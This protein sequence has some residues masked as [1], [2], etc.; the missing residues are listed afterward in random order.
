MINSLKT[1]QS[2]TYV[3]N[4]DRICYIEGESIVANL[5]RGYDTIWAYYHENEK[6]NITLESLEKNVGI[7]INC[8]TF[9][10]AEMPHFFSSRACPFNLI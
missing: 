8:G 4:N 5:V 6:N 2:S 7:I 1:Y 10:Y 3:V 9:S